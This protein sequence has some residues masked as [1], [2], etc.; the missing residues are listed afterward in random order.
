MAGVT[1]PSIS[2]AVDE[3]I[4]RLNGLHLAER[5]RRRDGGRNLEAV[6]ARLD[7]AVP[8]QLDDEPE[9]RTPRERDERSTRSVVDPDPAPFVPLPRRT[10]HGGAYGPAV[11]A[12]LTAIALD[13]ESRRW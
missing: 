12:K 13:K 4:E 9:S 5:N 7:A 3:T 2:S 11:R 10:T 8:V 1:W 6:V